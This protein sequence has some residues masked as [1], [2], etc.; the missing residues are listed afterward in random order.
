MK[1]TVV[2]IGRDSFLDAINVTRGAVDRKAQLPILSH[3]LI[4]ATGSELRLVCSSIETEVTT[5]LAVSGPAFET[6]LPSDKLSEILRALPSGSEVTLSV[7]AA[8]SVIS[9]GNGRY[10]LASFGSEE[11]PRMAAPNTAQ[12]WTVTGG[13]LGLL[14]KRVSS[15][16]SNGDARHYLNGAHFDFQKG[17]V[18]V[19]ASDGHRLAVNTLKA[20]G[21]PNSEVKCICHR[22]TIGLM[23]RLLDGLESD[24][25]V[26]V[27]FGHQQ[28]EMRAGASVIRSRSVDGAYP[29]YRR[30]IPTIQEA[31][32]SV[33]RDA[34]AAAARMCAIVSDQKTNSVRLAFKENSLGLSSENADGE[35]SEVQVPITYTGPQMTIWFNSRFLVDALDAFDDAVIEI[36]ITD[37]NNSITVR[38]AGNDSFIYVVMPVRL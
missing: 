9:C 36:G 16:M 21:L 1:T 23:I 28:I 3:V 8:N 6:T 24:A 37:P 27:D 20:P 19:V 14:L 4:S 12:T 38:A 18:N 10:R 11:F 13:V 15:A 29:D 5:N 2:K 25:V 35:T 34:I 22:N 33:D 26:E 32:V 7:G 30:V 17:A 31:N